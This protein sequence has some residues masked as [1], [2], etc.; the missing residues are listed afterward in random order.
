MKAVT[1]GEVLDSIPL[2]LLEPFE[3]ESAPDYVRGAGTVHYL[4][5]REGARFV[6]LDVLDLVDVTLLSG[7]GKMDLSGSSVVVFSGVVPAQA[8]VVAAALRHA[9]RSCPSAELHLLP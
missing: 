1:Y 3:I 6:Q 7:L 9:L 4:L 8:D 5:Q 2:E